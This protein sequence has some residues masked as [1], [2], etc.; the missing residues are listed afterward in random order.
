MRCPR[1]HGFP[2]RTAGSLV[3]RSRRDPYTADIVFLISI[4]SRG[5]AGRLRNEL[6]GSEVPHWATTRSLPL[7]GSPSTGDKPRNRND[8]H[9]VSHHD[10][11]PLP[12]DL[13]PGLFQRLDSAQVRD[14]WDFSHA[15][16]RHVHFSNLRLR[17]QLPR[18]VQV[19]V[20]GIAN[21][22][23]GLF[24]GCPLR[25]ASRQSRTA[26]A[27]SFFGLG[28]RHWILHALRLPD[29]AYHADL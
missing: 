12:H 23:Q 26:H 13:E 21:V 11:V 6:E 1:M 3:I 22:R 5:W 16:Y 8:A 24:L 14:A 19:L 9:S 10:M 20:D 29:V 18:H 7:I 4:V 17:G 27:V 2:N 25:P 15:L 28:E